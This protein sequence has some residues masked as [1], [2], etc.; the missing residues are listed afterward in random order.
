MRNEQVCELRTTI[1]VGSTQAGRAD[2]ERPLRW[3]ESK[4]GQEESENNWVRKGR[5]DGI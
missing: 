3:R 4:S 1:K 5:D 2:A